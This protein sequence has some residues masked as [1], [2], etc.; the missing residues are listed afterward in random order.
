MK[1][2]II[3][4]LC[5]MMGIFSVYSQGKKRAIF[6]YE[7]VNLDESPEPN[8][9]I[10]EVPVIVEYSLFTVQSKS[11]P[12]VYVLDDYPVTELKMQDGMTY[13]LIKAKKFIITP[14][15]AQFGNKTYRLQ[16]I[17][18]QGEANYE[19]VEQIVTN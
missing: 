1:L 6:I 7:K 15:K 12:R 17:L 18:A 16:I 19:I 14:E 10:N 8:Y 9:K 5:L 13:Q 11:N 3:V 4:I 2:K